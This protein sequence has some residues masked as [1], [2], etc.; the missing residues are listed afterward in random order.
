M[1]LFLMSDGTSD[2]KEPANMMKKGVILSVLLLLSFSSSEAQT[3]EDFLTQLH[4]TPIE[5]RQA[6]VDSFLLV[7]PAFPF[8]ENDT[9]AHFLYQGNA[10]TVTV[11]GDANAWNISGSPMTLIAGTDLWYRTEVYESDARLDYKFVLNGSTWILDPRNPNT[12]LGGFGPNSELSMPAYVPPPEIQFDPHIPHGTLQDTVFHSTNLDNSRTIRI[13]LPPTYHTSTDSFAMILFHDGLEY[14]SLANA[15]NVLDY[16]IHHQHIEPILAVFVPPVNRNEEYAGSLRDQFTDFI[17]EEVIPWVDSRFRTIPHPH[18]RA[19]LGASNGGNISLW[20]AMNH[21]E[22]FA[23]V[24]A[25]SSYIQSSISDGF[26]NGPVLDL[27]LYLDLGTYDIPMLIPLVRSFVPIL[28]SRGYT[29]QYAEYHEGHSWGMWRAHIDDALELFFPA[30]PTSVEPSKSTPG[31]I[32]LNQNFPNPFNSETKIKFYLKKAARVSMTIY[33]IVGQRVRKLMESFLLP[34]H[35]QIT[36]D[37]TDQNG[38]RQSSG[39]YFCQL[40]INGMS[41]KAHRMVLLR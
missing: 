27:K 1:G 15:N 40:Q 41:I 9:L 3:F 30:E 13:Y 11:P 22:V 10:S 2:T 19:V 34:G 36:W 39:I 37:G 12:I 5:Q 7:V 21:P 6:L 28:Q 24:A 4:S 38:Q 26:Q 8:V 20:L 23:N 31:V 33:N 18:E 29:Y 16:L 17:I 14:I 35:H 25:Q 32:Q